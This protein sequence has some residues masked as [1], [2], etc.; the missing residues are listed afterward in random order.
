MVGIVVVTYNSRKDIGPCLLSVYKSSYKRFKVF[1]VDNNSIDSTAG[2]VKEKFPQVDISVLK[3]NIGFA[4]G[5]NLG[6]KKALKK[7]C[8]SVFLLNPDTLIDKKCLNE[9]IIKSDDQTILQ[10]LI[11]IHNGEKKTK[12][13][14]TTGGV[15]NFLG[16]SYC[17]NYRKNM[18]TVREDR[19]IAVASGAAMFVPS[20]ILKKVGLFDENFFMYHE[21]V[22]LTY[23][24]RISGYNIKLISSALVWHKYSFSKN[25]QKY[26]HFEKNRQLFLWRNF[27]LKYLILIFP[28][29][30]VTEILMLIYSLISG[31]F[32]LKIKSYFFILKLFSKE[33]K[34]RQKNY[35]N[36]KKNEKILK[37]YL[38][39]E[40]AFSEVKNPL[41]TPYNVIL[42]LYWHLIKALI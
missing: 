35:K 16:F 34:I 20:N 32:L 17:G 5:Q 24:A 19:D 14:N 33:R 10:P 22:D 2:F 26:Y 29:Y 6:I 21:D 28:A 9:L 30:I 15:L 40:I 42:M 11:L 41:F 18:D 12:L 4:A 3:K 23:R 27:S 8:K 39:S 37:K 1:L 36:I 31:W 25:K 38:C 13:I 7:G